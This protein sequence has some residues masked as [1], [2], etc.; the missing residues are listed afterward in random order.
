MSS[1]WY[2]IAYLCMPVFNDDVITEEHDNY[3]NDMTSCR[4]EK[5]NDGWMIFHNRQSRP[6]SCATHIY[7]Y[8][9]IHTSISKDKLITLDVEWHSLL[10]R[11]GWWRMSTW[12]VTLTWSYCCFSNHLIVC[13]WCNTYRLCLYLYHVMPSDITS[14]H[15][16]WHRVISPLSNLISSHLHF[17]SCYMNYIDVVMSMW[18]LTLL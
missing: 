13:T 7:M 11:H 6:E 5:K 17:S 8:M 9:W 1:Q 10:S 3:K 12:I 14:H 2:T 15:I 18:M 16:T 4:K